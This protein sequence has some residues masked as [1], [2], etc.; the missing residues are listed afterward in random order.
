[1][2]VIDRLRLEAQARECYR[3]IKD[4]YDLLYADLPKLAM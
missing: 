4:E 3:A 2:Q 1:M